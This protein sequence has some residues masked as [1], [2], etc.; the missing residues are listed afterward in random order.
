MTSAPMDSELP[1]RDPHDPA[2]LPDE[3]LEQTLS[4]PSAL[5][6]AHGGGRN[7]LAL[8]GFGLLA[9]IGLLAL[10]FRSTPAQG[11]QDLEAFPT[12]AQ[13]PKMRL[14]ET[15]PPAFP[16]AAPAPERAAF[17]AQRQLEM[18]RKAFADIDE[19]RRKREQR[20]RSPMVVF[21]RQAS[22]G[23]PVAAAA[24]SA[25]SAAIDRALA[26]FPSLAAFDNP[27]LTPGQ[28]AGGGLS[29]QE[30][31]AERV[32]AEGVET[33]RVSWLP[34]PDAMVPQGT[35][36][37]AVLET[38]LQSDLPGFTRAQVSEDVYSFTGSRVLIPKGSRLIGKYQ[39]GLARGQSRV[40]VIWQR[41]LRPDGASIQIASPGTDELGAAGVSGERDTHFF[42][43]FGAAFLL[44]LVDGAVELAIAEA[45]DNDNSTII[46]QSGQG[47]SRASE[48]A[49][50]DSIG[51]PPTIRVAAGTEVQVFVARDL[52][53]TDARRPR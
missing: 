10:N 1:D 45:Q 30:Q 20:L 13:A 19:E 23:A 2:A 6:S 8:L 7:G 16:V 31:F 28:P 15:P 50:E 38:S 36:V 11:E 43:R 34:N 32:G 5:P 21:D 26:S 53:F 14:P 4:R 39:S 47:F 12:L 29:S 17:D 46:R 44:S 24:P 49:L 51:I 40:F 22:S 27:A 37:R 42:E 9:F 48:L 41:I 25:A 52:D 18:Q 35:L 3:D 33:A